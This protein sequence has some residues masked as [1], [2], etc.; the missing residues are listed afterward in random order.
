MNV[1]S[2]PRRTWVLITTALSLAS[3]LAQPPASQTK[4]SD[5]CEISTPKAALVGDT[6]QVR[7][8][9]TGREG[10]VFL[11]CDLKTQDHEMIKWG[12]PPKPVEAGGEASWALQV[13][14][15]PNLKSAYALV[16][17]TRNETDDW[18]KAIAQASSAPIEIA[19]RSP[20]VD[21]TYKKSWLWVDASNDGKPLVSG[22]T[23]E[24]PVEYYLDPADHY[25][26]TTL[27]IWGTGP[28]IDTP[29]GK[30]TKERGH[31]GYPG[32]GGRVDLT[33]PGRGRQVFKW[34]VPQDLEL[35]R[36]SNRILL[37][38]TFRD[39]AGQQW[40]WEHR[41]NTSFMRKRGF[42]EIETGVPGN[43]F[44]YDQ[45]VRVGIRLKNVGAGASS[46]QTGQ[47]SPTGQT[48]QTKTLRYTIHDTTGALV[49]KGEKEFAVQH[50]GQQVWIEPKLKRRGVFLLEVEVPGWE[51]RLTTVA[52]IPDLKA[53]TKGQPTRFGMTNHWEAPP[54][55]V[56]AIAQRLGLSTCRRF[57]NW[58]R[59]NPGPGVYKLDDL[60]TELD[61]AAKYGVTEWVCLV[62]PP[63]FAFP[64]KPEATSYR[65]FDFVEDAWRDFV[66]TATTRLK[67]KLYGWE[68][69]NEITPGG[70][71]DPVGT[72]VNMC[73]IGTETAK[74]AD[75]KI[76]TILAGGLYPRA[77]R[78]QVLTAGIGKYVDAL[79]VHYQN[80]DGIN[81]ARQDLDAVGNKHV[82]VW[83]DESAKGVNA[84]GMPPLE[85]LQNTT[86]CEWVLRQ[87]TDELAAGCEKLTY[88]GGPGDAA[89]SW[90][91]LLDD[92]SP[93]PVAATLAV[94]TSKLQGATPLGVFL[95]GE[96][97]LF[98]LFERSGKPVLVAATYEQEGEPVSLNVGADKLTVT[99]YQG[100]ETPLPAPGGAAQL[101]LSTLPV[102]VEGRDLDAMKAQVVPEIQVARVGSGTSANV[103]Q[104]RRLTPRVSVLQGVAGKLSVRLRN[105][106]DRTLSGSVTLALPLG[107]PTAKPLTFSL[108]KGKEEVRELSLPVPKSVEPKDYPLRLTFAL[109]NSA[110]RALPLVEKVAVVSVI[111]PDMLGNLLP[112]GDFETPDA[113]STGPEGWA[114]NGT[115]RKWASSEGL[116]DGLG[117]HVFRFEN[118]P[119]WEHCN[120]TIPLRGGQTYLYTAWVRNEN[121]DA[122]SN[123]TQRL[124]DGKEI[125]LYDTQVMRCGG[126]NPYWQVY[127]RRLGIHRSGSS[128]N[129]TR[130]RVVSTQHTAVH[131]EASNLCNSF[132]VFL[133]FASIAPSPLRPR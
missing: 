97:G 95:L 78:N 82:A 21:L 91:Y 70:C 69:L 105:L 100:N 104:S 67:G 1:T 22:D 111:S 112:N 98:H 94:L 8:K 117:K 36:R 2:R 42:F 24:V 96:G 26:K 121:M 85:E 59:L 50:A 43:L 45:P 73:K 101:R 102:F 92:L 109:Q 122:G 46:D 68:W 88:F 53:I 87:W 83:E 76:V 52:R 39:A 90:D 37:I 81:E 65:A 114:V 86:Q 124:A 127:S 131:A 74:A 12:G 60:A 84:W 41:A 28:W 25:Q 38:A 18:Q 116:G 106:Y 99:D 40:P 57:T 29:D 3:C 15:V 5:W 75:S 23:W 49:D 56:W 123:M 79:P 44:A 113:A 32:L 108:D 120:R 51:K 128:Q 54:A 61:T 6:V 89:G 16:I 118:S 14:D 34:T 19:G 119:D 33:E 66:K 132:G 4:Q 55:E 13:L 20:L 47:T 77:F 115:T 72:Y 71:A 133:T 103:T 11:T 107:W 62:D 64:G 7:V 126:N 130:G 17:A 31:I 48:G 125:R 10:K 27:S 35:V 63:P 58:Y 9:R 110:A 30:Y 129:F 80:G 93:R